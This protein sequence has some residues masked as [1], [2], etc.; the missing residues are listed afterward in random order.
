MSF[1]SAVRINKTLTL[2]MVFLL[3]FLSHGEAF[4]LKKAVKDIGKVVRSVPK[5]VRSVPS[6]L[7]TQIDIITG[8]TKPK[9]I[10]RNEGQRIQNLS[11]HVREVDNIINN[12]INDLAQSVGGD[13]GRIIVEASTGIDR[14][15]KEF[16]LTSTNTAGLILQGQDPL[17]AVAAPLAAAIRDAH[18]KY[19]SHSK[20]LPR[21]FKKL[22]AP[23]I[24]NHILNRVRYSVDN[25]KISLPSIINSGQKMFRND[26]AVVVGNII[27]FSKEPDAR[28]PSDIFWV[29]HE[30][31]HVYQYTRWGIDRFALNYIRNSSRVESEA[32]RAA[33]TIH[34]LVMRAGGVTERQFSR[35]FGQ[36]AYSRARTVRT[37]LGPARIASPSRLAG[38]P[39]A[40]TI[41]DKCVVRGERIVITAGNAVVS[42]MRF[43]SVV[44]RRV[45]PSA[46]QCIFEL[47]SATTRYCVDRRD[48][49][50]FGLNIP[51]PLGRCVPCR[52]GNC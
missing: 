3:I 47:V 34:A 15:K 24:P 38:L 12:N 51:F 19:S 5:I 48:G 50:V 27:V 1:L 30:I 29:A 18:N 37:P 40:Q 22:Y 42:P 9:N 35:S 31:H 16:L 52:F 21:S 49:T 36:A 45:R 33:S 14:Y 7:N 10:I 28:K 17:L 25:L 8:K 11:T 4:S 43:H 20:P 46:P 23:F 41:T 39:I 26:H 6:P 2:S 32:D 13:F 44:G